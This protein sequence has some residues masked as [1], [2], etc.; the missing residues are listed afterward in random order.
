MEAQRYPGDFDG[1]V[2]GAPA[3]DWSR[4]F[5]GGAWVTQAVLETPQSYVPKSTGPSGATGATGA[6]SGTGGTSAPPPP[7]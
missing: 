2:A 3:N 1:I 7:P 6:S 5:V 4:L